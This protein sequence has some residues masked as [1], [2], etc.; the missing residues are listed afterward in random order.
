MGFYFD[1]RL[2]VN[3]S[4]YGYEA[5]EQ[6]KTL[7]EHALEVADDDQD[8]E[9]ASFHSRESSESVFDT[10]TWSPPG[11]RT[12]SV[13]LSATKDTGAIGNKGS[14]LFFNPKDKKFFKD[15]T[16]KTIN[17]LKKNAVIMGHKTWED[18]PAKF[19]PL[20]GRISLIIRKSNKLGNIA[21]ENFSEEHDRKFDYPPSTSHLDEDKKP[22]QNT[23]VFKDM[24]DALEYCQ[25]SKDIESVFIG[26]GQDLYTR[27]L[28]DPRCDKLYLTTVNATF[29]AYRFVSKDLLPPPGFE[30]ASELLPAEFRGV[31]ATKDN[32]VFDFDLYQR[33][34]RPITSF[35]EEVD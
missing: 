6:P 13:I 33:T 10:M 29:D 26:G 35:A 7:K 4:S 3:V 24:E 14:L 19:R 20:E 21:P 32:I 16:T 2:G 28:Q 8:S 22:L 12:F 30:H 34:P 9:V 17:P 11:P 23:L 5:Q 15:I 31:F 1:T 25:E 18:I 27:A